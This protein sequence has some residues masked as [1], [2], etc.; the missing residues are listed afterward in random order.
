[1]RVV[2]NSLGVDHDGFDNYSQEMLD[3]I[4]FATTDIAATS[5]WLA[6]HTGVVA[7]EGGPHVNKGTRNRLCSFGNTYLEIIGPDPEQ[8]DPGEPRSFGIDDLSDHRVITWCARQHNLETVVSAGAAVGLGYTDPVP[9]RRVAPDM[10]LDWHLSLPTGDTEGGILPFFIDWGESRHPS[11][12]AAP[13]LTVAEIHGVHPD[14]ERV[15]SLLAALG[16]SMKVEPGDAPGLFVELS[17]PSGSV[18]L[19]N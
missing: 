16:E 17:G 14:P 7:T 2:G 18:I 1:M 11:E 10:T 8:G 5:E 19:P 15:N 3:H 4:V 12:T 13:G 6:D 9:M